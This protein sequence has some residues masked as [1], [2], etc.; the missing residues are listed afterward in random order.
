MSEGWFIRRMIAETGGDGSSESGVM[1]SGVRPA[2]AAPVIF[3]P[4]CLSAFA[5][6]SAVN[7]AGLAWK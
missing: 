5:N 4:S 2:R 7:L 3:T 1:P 6:A